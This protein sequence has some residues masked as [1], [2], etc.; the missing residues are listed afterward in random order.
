MRGLERK[1]KKARETERKAH[2]SVHW[3]KTKKQTNTQEESRRLWESKSSHWAQTLLFHL[4]IYQYIPLCSVS[5][6]LSCPFFL[7]NTQCMQIHIY[8]WNI[9][10]WVAHK[11]FKAGSL[12]KQN[13][14][15]QAYK[16]QALPARPAMH[17]QYT[18][19][20]LYERNPCNGA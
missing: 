8:K 11:Q 7:L 3:K 9:Q 17:L 4:Q 1:K 5:L 6:L 2:R 16:L 15:L 12:N 18:A 10:A 13:N 19:N 20:I 14:L